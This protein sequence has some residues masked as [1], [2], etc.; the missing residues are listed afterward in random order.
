MLDYNMAIITTDGG[1][2]GTFQSNHFMESA[3]MGQSALHRPSIVHYQSWNRWFN[4]KVGL[5]VTKDALS[6][7]TRYN[8]L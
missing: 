5:E 4:N 2:N 8:Y 6:N 3:T 7:Q 1:L